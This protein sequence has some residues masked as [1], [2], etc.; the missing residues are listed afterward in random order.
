GWLTRLYILILV[1][2]PFISRDRLEAP[3]E[4]ID[5]IFRRS[6]VESVA[7]FAIQRDKHH[8]L[9]ADGQGLAAYATRGSI[10]LACGD[11]IIPDNL[12]TQGVEDYIRHCDRHGWTACI[13]L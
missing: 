3:R 4:D 12:F 2:R 7:A 9:V 13:Y 5:R 11:P 1:L 6:G 8:L 10:A